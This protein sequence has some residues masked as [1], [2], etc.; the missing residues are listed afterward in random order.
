MF[1]KKKCF[2]C[3]KEIEKGKVVGAKVD[4][5]GLIG[6]HK[7]SFCSEDCLEKYEEIIERKMATRREGVCMSCVASQRH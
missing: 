7:K 5:Y 2:H 6:K 4:V 1:F 3:K